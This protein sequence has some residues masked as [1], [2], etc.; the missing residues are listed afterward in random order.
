MA[1]PTGI[2]VSGATAL[3]SERKNNYA[4]PFGEFG[5]RG[6]ARLSAFAVE[7]QALAAVKSDA[8]MNR[9]WLVLIQRDLLGEGK[10]HRHPPTSISA[11]CCGP[12]LLARQLRM[13]FQSLVVR[14][15]G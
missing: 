12:P 9:A 5:T 13:T 6:L 3:R 7:K 2:S 1:V 11:L 10:P 8:R 14:R 4:A 15:L